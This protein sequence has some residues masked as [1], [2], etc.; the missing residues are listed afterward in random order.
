[1]LQQMELMNSA[2]ELETILSQDALSGRRLSETQTSKE[3]SKF[4][5]NQLHLLSF[6]RF[7]LTRTGAGGTGYF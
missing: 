1:M 5:N 4:R 3:A 2:L 6:Y 7:R